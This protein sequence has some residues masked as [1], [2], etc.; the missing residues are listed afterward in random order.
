MWC[1]EMA[2]LQVMRLCTPLSC[3]EQIYDIITH[4]S[5]K[6]DEFLGT[7]E[8]AIINQLVK[9]SNHQRQEI[10]LKYKVMY[11]KVHEGQLA[12]GKGY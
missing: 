12:V 4:L 7:D 6:F 1:Q 9:C 5:R 8:K 2:E 11:G 10:K 3:R